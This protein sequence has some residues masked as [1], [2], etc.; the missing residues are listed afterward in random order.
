M[1]ACMYFS[2]VPSNISFYEYTLIYY[3][4]ICEYAMI[5]IALFRSCWTLGC[6]CLEAIMNKATI[7]IHV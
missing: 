7:N 4:M 1:V 2:F 6:F 3:T 5:L